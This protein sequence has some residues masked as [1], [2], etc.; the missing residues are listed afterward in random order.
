MAFLQRQIN[1]GSVST[2]YDIENSCKF[3]AD[4]REYLRWTNFSSQASAARKKKFTFSVWVKR[5]ELGGNQQV[6]ISTSQNGYLTFEANNQ[7]TW[8]QQYGGSQLVINTTRVFRDTSAWYHIMVVVDTAQSTEA[9]RTK[10]YVNGE[11]ETVFDAAAYPSQNAEASNLFEQH[12][13][14]GEW[15]GTSLG[16]CGYMAEY[17]FLS[18]IAASPT[19]LGEFDEDSGIWKP[20]EYDGT[21]SSPSHFLE[22]KDGSDLGTATSGLDSDYQNNLTAADQSTD[23]PT[24]NFCTL[25]YINKCADTTMTD[26]ATNCDRTNNGN[27]TVRGTMAVTKGKWYWEVHVGRGTVNTN[28]PFSGMTGNLSLNPCVWTHEDA[29][30]FSVSGS[31]NVT[32]VSTHRGTGTAAA[33]SNATPAYSIYGFAV[34]IDNETLIWSTNG[35]ANNSGNT[36]SLARSVGASTEGMTPMLFMFTGAQQSF[37]FGGYSIYPPSS[38]ESDANGYGTFE[39][40]PPSGYYA[41]CGKNLAEY[42]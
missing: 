17:Y 19:D 36:Y 40:A 4:N 31:G 15:G 9:D 8:I 18:E 10:I 20:K 32:D 34:D 12:L 25:N 29:Q 26:G 2:G 41:L 3:E 13:I 21:I 30:T 14:V 22:F 38:A 11:Q 37:N 23:T 27:N 33:Y 16:F 39:Y 1:R 42:G 24:N 7:L 35:T 28:Y 6:F 5:T